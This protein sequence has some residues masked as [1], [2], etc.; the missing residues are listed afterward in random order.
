[1]P[2]HGRFAADDTQNLGPGASAEAPYVQAPVESPPQTP[3]NAGTS[4]PY[5]AGQGP[6][7][8]RMATSRLLTFISVILRILAIMLSLLVVANAFVSGS[9]RIRVV[10]VT[11]LFSA[12]MPSSLSGVL[13]RETP[14]GGVLRGDFV[15]AALALFIMDWLLARKARSLRLRRPGTWQEV[16]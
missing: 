2:R 5:G 10:N 8:S 4:G 16:S 12:L 13:V 1:M 11:A 3:Y 9:W 6:A 15:I 14:F 7:Q